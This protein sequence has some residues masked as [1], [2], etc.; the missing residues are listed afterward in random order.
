MLVCGCGESRNQLEHPERFLTIGVNDVGR[1][2]QPDDLVVV[3]SEELACVAIA[4][5]TVADQAWPLRSAKL[6]FDFKPHVR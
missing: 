4:G 2:F 3:S 5:R 1:R 6:E